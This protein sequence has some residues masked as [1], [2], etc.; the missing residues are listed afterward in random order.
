MI[1]RK[2][3]AISLVS[4]ENF[5]FKKLTPLINIEHTLNIILPYKFTSSESLSHCTIALLPTNLHTKPNTLHV[6]LIY[7]IHFE[8]L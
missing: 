6:H 5:W 3:L 7:Y 4:S 2:V 1:S 8:C